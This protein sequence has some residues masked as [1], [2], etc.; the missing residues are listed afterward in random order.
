MNKTF[1]SRVGITGMTFAAL[2]AA[3]AGAATARDEGGLKLRDMQPKVKAPIYRFGVDPDQDKKMEEQFDSKATRLLAWLPLDAFEGEHNTGNDCWGYVSPSGRE[4]AIIGL[5]KGFGIVEVTNPTSPTIIK[6]IKGPT[7]LWHDVKVIGSVAYG[8][9][10]G[11]A[12]MQVMDLSRIDEGEVTHVQNRMHA[13]H[14][15]THN[16][17]SNT[18]TGYLYLC[19]PNIANGG[20]VAVSTEDPLN[21]TIVGAWP[22]MYVHDA[23]VVSYK[24]GPYAG[25]EI[26]FCASGFGNGSGDTALRI[27]DVTDKT[28]MHTIGFVEWAQSQY[29]HQCWL[30]EDRKFLLLGDELDNYPGVGTPGPMRTIVFDVQD[31]FNPLFK[32]T[33]GNG[34]NNID[35][36][37]YVRNGKSFQADYTT[38]LRVFD[39]SD[40]LAAFQVAWFDTHPETDAAEFEGAWSVYPFF[41]SGSILIS[42]I[43]RG[44]FVVR[45]ECR[46]DLNQDGL[47]DFFDFLA[48]Q[49]LFNAGD[50]IAD[51]DGNGV[52]DFFDFLAFQNEF[53]AGCQS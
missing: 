35:H 46:P 18:D 41:E 31:P 4:Y 38:G 6:T 36:N 19:G 17:A 34:L 20:L 12:G 40:P 7:S 14:S 47:L 39:V 21:P 3:Y 2:L 9:S 37:Q 27:V 33:F 16:I 50:P 48:F 23:Q 25:R 28:N 44:L 53:A 11:G 43:N 49:N 5:E 15:T 30:T 24:E 13:G 42:D 32:G 22:D 29:S 8:V 52:L 26:A 1:V 10:E 45:F 51:F